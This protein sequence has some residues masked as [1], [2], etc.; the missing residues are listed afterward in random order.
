MRRFG[1]SWLLIALFLFPP[2][3]RGQEPCI[4]P[5]GYLDQVNADLQTYGTAVGMVD[6]LALPDLTAFYIELYSVRQRYEDQTE[7][8]PLCG[9]R[10]HILVIGL[11]GNLQDLTGL[12]L[13]S[14]ANPAET[15]TYVY[16]V[17]R[18]SER[19]AAY[20]ERIETELIRVQRDPPIAVRYLNTQAA[21]VRTGAGAEKDAIGIIE[22]GARL[23][24]VSIDLDAND[25]TWYEF[26]YGE[27]DATGW[28]LGSLT[29]RTSPQ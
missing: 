18:L 16:E 6:D 3:A 24:V 29:S 5:A 1:V 27:G 13:V 12:A 26:Y 21:N 4:L 28:V 7:V 9:T 8:M 10:L 15:A 20:P 22:F 17:S 23:E 25:N 2:L 14:L 11:L 19:I